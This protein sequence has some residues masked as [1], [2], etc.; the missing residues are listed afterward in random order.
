MTMSQKTVICM[1]WG[2]RYGPEFVNRLYSAVARNMTGNFRFVCFTDDASGFMEGIDHQPLPQINIP[3]PYQWTPW[4]KLSCWQ[5]PLANLEGDVL[6]LD[7]DLLVVGSLDE[8]FDYQPGKY[9][10]IENW[11]QKGQNIGNTSAYRFPAG[12]YADIFNNFNND[13]DKVL[14]DCR[15]EQQYISKYIDEQTFWPREW[16]R[17]F[18]HELVPKFPLNWFKTPELPEDAKIVAFTGKPDPD[19]AVIGKWDAPFYKKFYKHTKPAAWIADHW[20]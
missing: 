18:K 19:E 2:T 5:Y 16:C 12:T 13:P 1:K 7:L 14:A 8:M 6:F 10:V 9:L 20:K 17:S 3:E 11:T 4:R 15:I